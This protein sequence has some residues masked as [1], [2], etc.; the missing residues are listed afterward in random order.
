MGQLTVNTF[1]RPSVPLA[2]CQL[3]PAA[4]K[5]VF[6]S[7]LAKS[8]FVAGRS[9]GVMAGRVFHVPGRPI[10]FAVAYD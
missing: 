5:G 7:A 3:S 10:P 1:S 9:F 4:L 8:R 6:L 2:C